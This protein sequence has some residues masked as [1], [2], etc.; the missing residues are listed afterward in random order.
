SGLP[1]STPWAVTI[2]G[3]T[4]SSISNTITFWEPSNALYA[5]SVGPVAGFTATPNLGAVALHG[6]PVFVT[7]TWT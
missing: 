3:Y 2:N 4:Q 6:G 5:Y 1:A 7:I